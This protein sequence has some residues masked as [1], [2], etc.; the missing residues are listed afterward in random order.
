MTGV[1]SRYIGTPYQPYIRAGIPPDGVLVAGS[2]IEPEKR[3]KVPGLWGGNGWVGLPREL[4]DRLTTPSAL[5]GWDDWPT[6][7]V[8]LRGGHFLGID[9]DTDDA[10]LAEAIA[11]AAERLLGPAP[12]RGRPGSAHCLLVYRL[13]AGAEPVRRRTLAWRLPGEDVEAPPAHL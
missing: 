6:E 1:F 2:K 11:A 4:Q 9:I 12:V 5:T 7:N 8:A 10:M 3:G 13:A